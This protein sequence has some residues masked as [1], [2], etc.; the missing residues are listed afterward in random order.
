MVGSEAQEATSALADVAARY[1]IGNVLLPSG[2]DRASKSL[3]AFISACEEKFTPIYEGSE[4]YQLDLGSGARL[5]VLALGG[6]GM[7]LAVERDR[8]AP[9][10]GTGA[11]WLIFDDVDQDL[12]RRLISQGRIPTAEVLAFPL[13]IKTNGNLTSWLGVAHSQAGLW[14]FADDLG[15]P[16]GSELLRS[17]SHG[18]V[19]LSTDG[20]QMW[21]RVEK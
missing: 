15:W 20:T 6:Q 1:A 3:A 5:T 11:R 8:P 2:A 10:V 7:I 19:D 4:G 9:R 21:V 14:P 13:S 17:D 16:E 12:G 18:W